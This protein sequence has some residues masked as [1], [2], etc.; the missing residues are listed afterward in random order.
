LLKA[1]SAELRLEYVRLAIKRYAELELLFVRIS[2]NV[3]TAKEGVKGVDFK[4]LPRP[5]LGNVQIELLG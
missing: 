2:M 3:D 4:N 5:A 1:R